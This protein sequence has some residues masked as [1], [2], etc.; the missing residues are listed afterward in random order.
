MF[1]IRDLIDPLEPEAGPII[2]LEHEI[3]SSRNKDGSPYKS[4]PLKNLEI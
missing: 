2:Q 1:R 4:C 3:R